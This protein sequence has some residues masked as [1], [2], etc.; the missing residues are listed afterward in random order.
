[1]RILFI[2]TIIPWPPNVGTVLRSLSLIEALERL[3]RVDYL[4][5]SESDS[6]LSMPFAKNRRVLDILPLPH[7]LYGLGW[8][9]LTKL[10]AMN[11]NEWLPYYVPRFNKLFTVDKAS[12]KKIQ[13]LDLDNYDVI[14]FVQMEAFWWFQ[15]VIK[16]KN[17]QDKMILDVDIIKHAGVKTHEVGMTSFLKIL[18]RKLIFI[19]LRKAETEAIKNVSI[20]LV[21]SN[22]DTKI[23]TT[24]NIRVIP[25]V[26]PD[27]GQISNEI[28]EN[29]SKT[30]L[31]VGTLTY[32]PNRLGIEYFITAILPNILAQDPFV[33]F[34][35]IGRTASNAHYAWSNAPGVDFVG[36]VD[37]PK[38][39]IEAAAI[40]VCPVLEGLGTRIKIIEALSYGKPMVSTTIGAYGISIGENDGLFRR[41]TVDDTVSICLDLLH[42]PL[43]RSHIGKRA[44]QAVMERYSQQAVNNMIEDAIKEIISE[45]KSM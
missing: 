33:T 24:S 14:F 37:D 41:D 12:S 3:G 20:A 5:F 29:D 30:I 17:I 27:K 32:K 42:D 16:N 4:F 13:S 44:K 23:L 19:N 35:I 11:K 40:E 1:M 8:D 38:P 9:L 22:E 15:S 21:C 31:F 34:Q 39:Y 10:F 2:S 26:F 45:S 7:F 28:K 43:K 18:S 36:T 25:N 6:I